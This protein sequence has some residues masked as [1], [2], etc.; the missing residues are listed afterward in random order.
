[1]V[2]AT[3]GGIAVDAL[4]GGALVQPRPRRG[5]AFRWF[6]TRQ[7]LGAAAGLVVLILIAVAVLAPALSPF[8]PQTFAGAPYTHPGSRLLLGTDSLGRDIASRLIWGAR[9]SLYVGIAAALIGVLGGAALGA[10]TSYVGGIA[11]LAAVRLVDGGQAFPPLVLA[12][13]LMGTFGASVNNVIIAVAIIYIPITARVVRPIVLSLKQS[14]YIEAARA[15][16]ASG[17]RVLLRHIVPN[18]VPSALVLFSLAI[19]NAIVVE[20]SLSFLGVGIP[21]NVASWGGMVNTAEIQTLAIAPWIML[22]PAA[23][24]ALSVYAFNL[25]GDAVRDAIDPKL[26]TG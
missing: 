16:G 4:Q 21:P 3:E 20:A 8:N 6:V 18:A 11:D 5:L 24:I 10:I 14:Q 2:G 23:A 9:I 1:M 15:S 22:A 19:G 13:V 25:L 17:T 12:L 7:P 26:R